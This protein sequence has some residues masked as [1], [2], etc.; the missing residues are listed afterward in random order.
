MENKTAPLHP[1]THAHFFCTVC[2]SVCVF[3]RK[4]Y[5]WKGNRTKQTKADRSVADKRSTSARAT[6]SRAGGGA[7]GFNNHAPC[8]TGWE[9]DTDR[10]SPNYGFSLT[11]FSVPL[12]VSKVEITASLFLSLSLSLLSSFCVFVH[13]RCNCLLQWVWSRLGLP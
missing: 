10:N 12:S 8:P 2:L 1:C 6:R 11:D 4:F 5:R 13:G 7:W 3:A 9:S